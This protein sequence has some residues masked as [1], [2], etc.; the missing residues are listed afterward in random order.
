[1]KPSS[2]LVVCTSPRTGSGALCSALWSSGCCGRPDEYFGEATRAAYEAEWGCHGDRPYLEQM[3]AHGTTP[4]GV[5][6][7]KV[8]WEQAVNVGWLDHVLGAQGSSASDSLRILAP[9]VHFVWLSRRDRVRQ[10]VSMLRAA[11]TRRYRS[12]DEPSAE[13]HEPPFDPA[14]IDRLVEQI[15]EFEAAWSADFA[16]AGIEPERIW[17]E[18]ALEHDYAVVARSVLE[19]MGVDA[20]D[21]LTFSTR[22]EKQSDETSE[23]LVRE[24]ARRVNAD[25]CT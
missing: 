5:F 15:G 12:Y 2:A 3:L 14:A 8:H 11:R 25:G 24:H 10:A 13:D 1:M 4:N 23:R 20:P 6:A 17:Y 7:V 19:S 16:A 21:D 9:D 22:Y 18:D